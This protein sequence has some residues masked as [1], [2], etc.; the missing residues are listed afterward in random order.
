MAELIN[1]KPPTEVTLDN[2]I[3]QMHAQ[4]R[5]LKSDPEFKEAVLVGHLSGNPVTLGPL[6]PS[7]DDWVDDMTNGAIA[8]AD[9]WLKRTL[10]PSVDPKAATLKAAGKFKTNMQTALNEGRFEKGVAAYD[11]SARTAVIQEG[12]TAAFTSGVQ[13]KKAKAKAKIAKLQPKVA[14]LKS[15]LSGMP[16]DTDAQREAKMIAAKRGMQQ[17]GKDMRGG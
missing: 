2:F 15:T 12:G 3:D 4:E 14:A 6:V 8:K 11:E 7:V 1:I 5:R 10:A 17:I 16:Q 9:K 13:R